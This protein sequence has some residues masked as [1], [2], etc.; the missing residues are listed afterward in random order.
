M[1]MRENL[2]KVVRY[3]A[4]FGVITAFVSCNSESKSDSTDKDKEM[5][6]KV[7][8]DV[9][10]VM[11]SLPSP[12]E[13]S[14]LLK[15]AGATYNESLLNPTSNASKYNTDKQKALNL[16]VYGADLSY[17]S[18]FEQD[19]TIMQYM[20]ISKKLAIGLDLLAAID[21][22]II[23]RLEANHD[24][25]DSVIR[26][27]SETFMNSNSS[28]KDDNRPETAALIL[29]GG[30]IEG[31]YLATSLVDKI[32]KKDL[33]ERIVEQKMSLGELKQL[34][35]TYKSN[36]DISDMLEAVQPI[37]KAFESIEIQKSD[38]VEVVTNLETK[39]TELKSQQKIKI[40]QKQ[41]DEL[42]SAVAKLRNSIIQ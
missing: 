14:L 13:T 21:Q 29:A 25:R 1:S 7:V 35:E 33:I 19:Q 30:W 34:L 16:G 18:I 2:F 4:L 32:E 31:L 40:T 37:I 39:Q 26:I 41:Y 6:A 22:S 5:K 9:K 8:Q 42:K 15:K 10:K 28:L 27:I 36:K 38:K 12:V 24:N 23:D 20:N 17:A 3:I 11:I